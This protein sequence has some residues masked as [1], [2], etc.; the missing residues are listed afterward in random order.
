MKDNWTTDWNRFTR[1]VE[2]RARTDGCFDVLNKAISGKQI[3]WRG[4]LIAV[5]IDDLLAVVR[6]MLPAYQFNWP[7]G[8]AATVRGVSLPVAKSSAAEWFNLPIGEQVTFEATVGRTPPLF[9][10][11]SSMTLESGDT[12]IT[13]RLS[14]GTPIRSTH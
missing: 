14:N 9:P 5:D 3:Q 13:V 2:H 12:L 11:V 7:E 8:G 1:L 10:S 6:V 4:V